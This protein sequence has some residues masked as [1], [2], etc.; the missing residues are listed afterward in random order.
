MVGNGLKAVDLYVDNDTED[1]TILMDTD[2]IQFVDTLNV[3]GQVTVSRATYSQLNN[4]IQNFGEKLMANDPTSTFK[5]LKERWG[6]ILPDRNITS[7]TYIRGPDGKQYKCSDVGEVTDVKTTPETSDITHEVRCLT[8][9]RRVIKCYAELVKSE[10][11]S[12]N[13]PRIRCV[14]LLDTEVVVDVV[15][16][17]DKHTILQITSMFLDATT[18]GIIIYGYLRKTGVYRTISYHIYTITELDNVSPVIKIGLKF[19]GVLNRLKYNA[20]KDVLYVVGGYVTYPLA[21]GDLVPSTDQILGRRYLNHFTHI[22]GESL[23]LW[24]EKPRGAYGTILYNPYRGK[25]KQD[26]TGGYYYSV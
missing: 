20:V 16:E 15:D 8:K 12:E 1:S 18:T 24:M 22:N 21:G 19:H 13:V 14:G 17:F 6:G 25:H 5:S 23:W 10:S 26:A 2:N 7:T 11:V 9:D 3:S 4:Y